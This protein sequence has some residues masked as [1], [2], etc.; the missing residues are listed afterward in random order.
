MVE[1]FNEITAL[2]KRL[3]QVATLI[4]LPGPS[5]VE[6]P[7]VVHLSRDAWALI[8][9]VRG[10]LE[11]AKNEVDLSKELTVNARQSGL[12]KTGHFYAEQ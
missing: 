9:L 2:V 6:S 7:E 10:S 1:L 4:R 8:L 12:R 5:D 11:H 3:Y